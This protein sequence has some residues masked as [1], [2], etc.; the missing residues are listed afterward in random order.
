MPNKPIPFER[1]FASHEK[2]Y[3]WSHKNILKSTEV[4]KTTPNK[5]LFEC[6][7][8]NH[9]FTTRVGI[10]ANSKGS[11][12]PYC[13]N[14]LLCDDNNCKLCFDKSFASHKKSKYLSWK[15]NIVPRKVFR[16]SSKKFIFIC[17][18][19]HYFETTLCSITTH[20]GWCPYCAGQK[21]CGNCDI[22]NK[23]SFAGHEKAAFWSIE[24]KINPNTIFKSS[25]QK[26]LFN[27]KCG[28][29]IF[30]SPYDIFRDIWC[31]YCTNQL[32]CGNCEQCNTKSFI[33]HEKAQYLRDK[34]TLE[35]NK[36]FKGSDKKLWFIC[37]VCNHNFESSVGEVVRGA[38][39]PYCANL[40]LCNIDSE[41]NIC[42]EKTFAKHEKSKYWSDK[43]VLKPKQVLKFTH[44]LYIFN[45]N[46]GHEFS[47]SC[48]SV[49]RGKWCPFCVNKTETK[50][51]EA[52][53]KYYPSL[54][55][56]YRVKWCKNN[57]TNRCY[58]FDFII[59]ELNII[60]ELDGRQHFIK[61]HK[62]G[63]PEDI[64]K[65]DKYKMKIANENNISVIRILQEDVFYNT[66]NWIEELLGKITK[67]K[68]DNTIQNI[69]MCKNNE[70]DIYVK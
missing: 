28:H 12:C 66:Y 36:I 18:C 6:N 38:W 52:L 49:C 68:I 56:Q 46:K 13:N 10:I 2:S 16:N 63:N 29:L 30:K 33:N 20:K 44:K 11:G 42:F 31:S 26:Y 19:F 37:N 32:L 67:I 41:C 35:I 70:Y 55:K 27:C 8:C 39:C 24:N 59:P 61:V 53:T 23:K 22:C 43:N 45:C 65:T 4:Y 47:Q 51:Y 17:D 25:K 58:P 34:D 64:Q 5:Y 54:I 21:L 60:I 14:A 1:S 62:W 7:I 69:F 15:N 50:L 48:A 57:K 40:K 9:E 3:L